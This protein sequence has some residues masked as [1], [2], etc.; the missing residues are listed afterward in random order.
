ML[1]TLPLTYCS[2]IVATYPTFLHCFHFPPAL[3]QPFPTKIIISV[4]RPMPLR[5]PVTI[6]ASSYKV[7]RVFSPSNAHSARQKETT[8]ATF[9]KPTPTPPHTHTHTHTYAH[10]LHVVDRVCYLLLHH[11]HTNTHTHTDRH[12]H[13]KLNS[14]RETRPRS[15]QPSSRRSAFQ[16]LSLFL[17]ILFSDCDCL[18]RERIQSFI[19]Q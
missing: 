9:T 16:H 19:V 12:I 8:S 14:R 18:R 1:M 2:A 15:G 5:L 3:L 7:H 10:R 11:L 17:P 6:I 4:Y 13:L